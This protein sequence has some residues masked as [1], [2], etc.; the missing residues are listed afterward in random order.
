MTGDARR[1]RVRG[2]AAA[3]RDAAVTGGRDATAPA[4]HRTAGD[5]SPRCTGGG[6][7]RAVSVTINYTL[8]LAM[9]TILISGLLF[10]VGN[11]V[12]DRR[13]TAIR[14]ELEVLGHRLAANLQSADRMARAGGPDSRVRI[15]TPLPETVAT[16]TYRVSVGSS[17]SQQFVRL[18]TTDPQVEVEVAVGTRTTIAADTVPGGT[19]VV[20]FDGTGLEVE[21][22]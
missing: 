18:S 11:T 15:E 22:G 20:V 2:G 3:A 9:A 10:A 4:P 13:E 14:S 6:D 16:T 7:D 1:P 21:S 17:G 8:N 12:E 5:G 19:V